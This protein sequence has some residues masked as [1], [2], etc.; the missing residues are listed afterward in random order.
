MGQLRR[1]LRDAVGARQMQRQVRG[2]V[3]GAKSVAKRRR[4]ELS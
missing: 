3:I 4:R 1:L 2:V